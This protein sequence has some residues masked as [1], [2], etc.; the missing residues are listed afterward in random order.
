MTMTH[1]SRL[2]ISSILLLAII[3]TLGLGCSAKKKVKTPEET[4]SDA[5]LAAAASQPTTASFTARVQAISRKNRILTLKMPEDKLAKVHCAPGVVNFDMIGVGDNITAD[6]DSE[7][8]VYIAAAS[9]KPLWD[10]VQEIKKAPKGTRPGSA[11]LRPYEYSGTVQ[12]V[13]ASTRQ[14]LMKA[15]DG[16]TL[17]V[18]AG[19]MVKRINEIKIGDR[20]VARFVEATRITV[21]PP[22][23]G[24]TLYRPARRR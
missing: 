5:A 16:K 11:V 17:K 12:G 2:R 15:M 18:T 3:A 4:A 20:L 22:E 13:D 8:E 24:S 6:F 23:T 1:A 19:P 14:I 7:V 10:E 9:G 21:S